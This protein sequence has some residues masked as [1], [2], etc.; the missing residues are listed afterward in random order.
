MQTSLL[1]PFDCPQAFPSSPTKLQ[2]PLKR[3]IKAGLPRLAAEPEQLLLCRLWGLQPPSSQKHTS[4]QAA[5][6]YLLCQHLPFLNVFKHC[7]K[8]HNIE[9]IETGAL[10][11]L[12]LKNPKY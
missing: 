1:L 3:E 8:L 10:G 12:R 7:V 5:P 4:A 6:R 2:Q 11:N 9:V